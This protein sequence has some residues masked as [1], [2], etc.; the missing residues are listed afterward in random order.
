MEHF[1]A[2]SE[3]LSSGASGDSNLNLI[4]QVEV[5]Q[6]QHDIASEN[7]RGIESNL[8]SRIANLEQE[9]EDNASRESYFRKK[10][11]TLSDSLKTQ[12]AENEALNDQI[13]ELKSQQSKIQAAQTQNLQELSD[14]KK[15]ILE[16]ESAAE[17]LTADYEKKLEA[18]QEKLK[19]SVESLNQQQQ[20]FQQRVAV[21]DRKRSSGQEQFHA[22]PVS[23]S[24]S[25]SPFSQRFAVDDAFGLKSP[26]FGFG[27]RRTS[28]KA[29]LIS[30]Q[31]PPIMESTNSSTSALSLEPSD[32]PLSSLPTHLEDEDNFMSPYAA[33]SEAYRPGS[34][35]SGI[36]PGQERRGDESSSKF[37]NNS[38]STVGAGPSIQLV[39]RMSRTIRS[40]ESE[41]SNVKE[42]LLRMTASKDE[43]VKD[44]TQLMEETE[45]L[46]QYKSQVEELENKIKEMSIRE[47]TTLEMLGEKSE[48]V[49]ELRA[50]V[51]DIKSMFQQQ[52]EELV[53]RL[54][55]QNK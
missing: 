14:A 36:G 40:L 8:Q 51:S 26:P 45:T 12:T 48:Q 17:K 16:L 47:Q 19:M 42:D 13:D 7:W 44:I 18:V 34:T 38:V 24:G 10:I 46:R 30:F 27:S 32:N 43:A 39:N 41:L 50:D 31:T 53:E 49:M 21:N 25:T 20:S 29:S 37:D 52:I 11:K 22:E 9:S 15:T 4:R 54:N 55:A 33:S 2:K 28:S 35:I 5:L 6:A 3:E 1:R 23:R